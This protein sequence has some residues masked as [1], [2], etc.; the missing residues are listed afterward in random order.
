MEFNMLE[1]GMDSYRVSIEQYR[2]YIYTDNKYETE[3]GTYL[4]G[5]IIYL[6]HTL[7]IFNKLI[8]SEFNDLLIFDLTKSSDI[9]KVI[10][11][12]EKLGLNG[13]LHEFVWLVQKSGVKTINYEETVNRIEFLYDLKDTYIVHTM[14]SIS[15]IRNS[16]AHFAYTSD[17]KFYKIMQDIDNAYRIISKFYIMYL[18]VEAFEFVGFYDLKELSLDLLEITES[19]IPKYFE[20]FYDEELELIQ[21]VFSSLENDEDFQEECLKRNIKVKIQCPK[22]LLSDYFEITIKNLEDGELIEIIGIELIPSLDTIVFI[23]EGS[24]SVRMLMRFKDKFET[25]ELIFNKT[26]ID[27]EDAIFIRNNYKHT[28]NKKAYKTNFEVETLKRVL[29]LNIDC[30]IQQK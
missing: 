22:Y 21:S 29:L 5:T 17:M 1:N 7:E 4:K 23:E 18:D 24:N 30:I 15:L 27:F 26:P 8:L 13:S 19:Q 11:E 10:K 16:I 3:A 6:Q 25:P 2:N 9:L 28:L 14:K 12:K 20:A